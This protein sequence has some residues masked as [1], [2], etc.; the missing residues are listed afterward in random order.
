M[1]SKDAKKKVMTDWE[2]RSGDTGSS[3]VQIGILTERIADIA[4]HLDVNRKDE[5]SRRGLV[6][7]VGRRRRLLRYLERTDV[8]SFKGVMSRIK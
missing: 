5:S 3:Q 4:Q 2:L 1:L 6:K 7:L 8:A